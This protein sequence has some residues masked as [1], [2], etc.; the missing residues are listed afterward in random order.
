MNIVLL[1]PP[2][3]GKGTQAKSLSSELRLRHISTGDILRLAIK[4]KSPLGKEAKK[5]VEAG[6][7]VPDNLVTKMVIER[8]SSND[9]KN[10]FILDGFP[11]NVNQA[12][13]L[14]D[15]L[16]SRASLDYL[17]LYLDVSDK[18]LIQRLSGRRICQMCQAV[19]HR[20]NM[21]PK[22]EGVCD[23][24]AGELYQRPDDT[25]ATIRNRLEVYKRATRPVVDYYSKNK[26]LV[27][28]DAGGEAQVVLQEMLKIL[29][30]FVYSLKKQQ[31]AK[32]TAPLPARHLA[33]GPAGRQVGRKVN[34]SCK[35][36]L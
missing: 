12:K 32:K 35:V 29:A 22:K 5:Y 3:A 20:M 24:C 18:I 26:R 25:E 17:T 13:D 33:G 14:D 4:Q 15:F 36:G 11:R 9:V 10:G 2:G 34:D 21:P 19:F 8:L 30:E 6:E 28:I 7:L 23:F 27:R 31:Q 1:G 16:S